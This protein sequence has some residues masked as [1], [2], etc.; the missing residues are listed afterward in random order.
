M[1]NKGVIVVMNLDQPTTKLNWWV[2]QTKPQ[3]ETL[4]MSHLEQQGMTTYCPMYQK[5][6]IHGLQVKTI[7]TP[8]FPRYGFVLAN[9]IAQHAV[10]AIRST[11]GVN[12]LLRVG[13]MP[14]TMDAS[15]IDEIRALE[16]QHQNQTDRY[17]KSNDEVRITGGLYQ[18][19][20]GIY[21]MDEGLER[22]VVLLSLLQK[23]TRLT[24]DKTQLRKK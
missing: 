7:V 8:L 3:A 22:A 1:I 10:H 13:D 16:A 24:L 20:E 5:E 2:V 19:L 23:D 17:F 12:R 9:Q 6:T 15:I 21:Q 4:A 11:R 14:S 18:G